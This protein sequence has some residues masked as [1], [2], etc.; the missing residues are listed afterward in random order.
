MAAFCFTIDAMI[1]LHVNRAD[2]LTPANAISILGLSMTIYGSFHIETLAGVLILGTGRL[3]DVFDGKVARATHTSQLGA[4]IDATC[5]K[6]GLLFLLPAVWFAHI[7]P[8]WL[9]MYIAVQ[10]IT[11]VILSSLTATRGKAPSSSRYGKYAMFLQNVSIGFYA[12]GSVLDAS[13]LTGI[14]LAVGIYSIYWA[15]RATYGYA[16]ALPARVQ[17]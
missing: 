6:L 11:N 17:K 13:I 1:N 5:D 7:A 12:L 15:I 10:N 16:R 9:L 2:I 4:A 14:G 3:I 8:Y